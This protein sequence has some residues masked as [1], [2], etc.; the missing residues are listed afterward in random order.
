MKLVIFI[1]TCIILYTQVFSKK[2]DRKSKSSRNKKS[3][4]K[5]LG[6]WTPD[7]D[8]YFAEAAQNIC[9]QVGRAAT[10]FM[11][12]EYMN[13]TKSVL[14]PLLKKQ[15]VTHILAKHPWGEVEEAL[16]SYIGNLKN[17]KTVPQYYAAMDFLRN[18]NNL[19]YLEAFNKI[20]K[21][22]IQIKTMLFNILFKTT[23]I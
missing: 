21:K 14:D 7:D 12:N 10:Y 6:S 5:M 9:E 15:G 19:E 11:F 1:F 3:K 2:M 18:K 22:Q 23:L 20:L 8:C 4:A 17:T 16:K 13:A